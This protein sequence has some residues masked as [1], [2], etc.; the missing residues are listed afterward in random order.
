MDEKA[1]KL[2]NKEIQKSLKQVTADTKASIKA[3]LEAAKTLSKEAK[4]QVTKTLRDLDASIK[5][6]LD[7]AKAG[8]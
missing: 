8:F 4:A 3:Q 7:D 5:S 6:V 2:I 1:Q